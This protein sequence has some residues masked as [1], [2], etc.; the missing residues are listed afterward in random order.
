MKYLLFILCLVSFFSCQRHEKEVAT[1]LKKWHGKEI[2]FPQESVFTLFGKDTVFFSADTQYKVLSYVDSID[3]ISCKLQLRSWK[4]LI[5]ELNIPVM[6]FMHP[7]QLQ[8]IVFVLQRDA[9]DYPV[10]IDM[11]D[12][13]N[14]LNHFLSEIS[15]R[16]FLLDSDNRVL[17]IGNPVH[18]PKVRDLYLDIILG[19]GR[20]SDAVKKPVLTKMEADKTRHSF[21]TFGWQEEQ[22]VLFTLR[23]TGDH[24]LVVQEVVTSCGCTS[25]DYP[26][27]P[28][29][30][31]GSMALRVTYKA[32][33]PGY[34]DKTVT[35]YANTDAPL[36]L[37][38]TGSAE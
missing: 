11:N 29:R 38:V 4:R 1:L 12:S 9:F 16:T 13:L 30:P 2:L 36:T 26:A 35:V 20:Y 22:S 27:E 28:V 34:F 7:K 24:P 5:E 25:V 15:F 32:D 37:R 33:N 17:A 10:C 8:E 19:R 18:N 6:F 14:K 31:G 3:C 23:N 21:G